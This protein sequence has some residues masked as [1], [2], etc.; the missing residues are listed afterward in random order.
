M[1]DEPRRRIVIVRH[2]ET[3]WSLSG[4][5]TGRTDLALT[6]AGRRKAELLGPALD[7][8]DFARAFT[9][10]LRRA[11]E[12]SALSGLSGL[13]EEHDGLME[14]DYGDYEG[15]TSA[16]IHEERPDWS[17]WLH[18]APGGESPEEVTRRVDSLVDELRALDGDVVV[19]SHGHLS[20]ALAVR[21]VGLPIEAGRLFRLDTGTVST[22]SWKRRTRVIDR[23][24]DD[25]HLREAG[26]A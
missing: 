3:E 2:A 22:L 7:R 11:S 16:E 6:E 20:R 13:A 18:G 21:W 26:E 10:P 8:F 1:S 14:W 23:W 24:N 25:A 17:L 9:S 5:H 4:Q 15:L 12:T 19:F